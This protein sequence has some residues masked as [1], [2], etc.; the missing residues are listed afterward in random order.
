MEQHI[1]RRPRLSRP[2]T[3]NW[4]TTFNDLITLMMVF[5]VLVFAMG[6]GDT[7]KIRQFRLAVLNGFGVL[8][9]KPVESNG[10]IEGTKP[11]TASA[12]KTQ[13]EPFPAAISSVLKEIAEMPDVETENHEKGMVIRI[14]GKL[15]FDSGSSAINP[16]GH[17]LLKRVGQLISRLPNRVRVEGHTDDMPISTETFPSNWELSAARAVNIVKFLSDKMNVH[18]R[19][20]SA[21]GYS[22]SRPLKPNNTPG[23]RASNRRVEIVLIR[24]ERR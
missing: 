1:A 9:G 6:K 19:R 24:E 8:E 17:S 18:P 4:L 7:K 5:F 23:N 12:K 20:L 13:G 14:S 22:D 21:V 15:F 10:L 2:P 3:V 11:E 16:G